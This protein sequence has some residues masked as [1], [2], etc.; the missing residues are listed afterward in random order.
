LAQPAFDRWIDRYNSRIRLG[1]FL[2]RAA[3]TGAAFLFAFGTVVLAVKLLVPQAWPN[4]LWSGLGLLPAWGLAWW[5][6]RRNPLASREVGRRQS[7]ARLDSALATGGLLMMLSELPESKQGDEWRCRLPQ[8]EQAWKEAIPRVRPRRFASFLALPLLFALGACFVPL[9]EGTTAVALR[10]TVG[11]QAAQELEALLDS[12][13][14]E[15]ILEEPEKQK[16]HEEIERLAEETRET[17]LTHEKW[18]TVDALRERMKVRIE[19]AAMLSSQAGAAAALLSESNSADPGAEL[20]AERTESLENELG[21]AMQKLMQKGAFSNASQSLQDKLARLSKDGKLR[22]PREGGERQELLDQLKEHLEKENKK[23]AELRKKCAACK[24]GCKSGECEGEG[25]CESEGLCKSNSAGNRPGRGGVTRGRGD[26]ELTWG[27]ESDKQ[28]TKFKEVVLP[29]GF[30]DQPKDDVVAVQKSAPNEEAAA[31]A[32]RSARR[33][34][35]AA[36]GQAT[37]N[38]K[39]APRHRNAVRKYFDAKTP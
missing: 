19:S 3:E 16:L 25:E 38:R 39:L 1:E 2:Q 26:A 18:E 22:M 27:D 8:F 4:V 32:P 12:I 35:E 15:K 9:R 24:S 23:L 34:D 6:A 17:P 30:L 33:N 10:N 36:A 29:K 5:L 21:E 11:Q 14:E 31:E 37:W 13:D 7:V 28:S 20:S